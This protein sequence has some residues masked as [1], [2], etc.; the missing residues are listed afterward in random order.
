MISIN[1]KHAPPSIPTTDRGLLFGESIYEVVAVYHQKPFQLALHLKRLINS[2][3]QL[4]QYQLDF[5]TLK[6]WTLN[7]IATLPK[8]PALAIYIHVSTGPMQIRSHIRSQATPTCIIQQTEYVPIDLNQYR[9]G[10]RAI[11]APDLRSS[12]AQHK[13]SQLALNTIALNRAHAEG[14]DDAIFTK[15]GT[16]IEGASSNIFAYDGKQLITPP[17][18][19][20]VPGITRKL[21]IEIAQQHH[22]PIHTAPIQLSSLHNVTEIFLSSSTKLLKPIIEIKNLF[23]SKRPGPIWKRLMSAYLKTSCNHLT[24]DA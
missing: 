23:H 22:I 4:Y 12:H 20:I 13:T 1:G 14:F 7:Y 19:D 5:N 6:Q 21:I 8:S 9:K 3:H 17:L 15:N 10:F 24:L 16:L 11:V 18:G 2:F